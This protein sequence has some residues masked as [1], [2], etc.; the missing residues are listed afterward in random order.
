MMSRL[1]RMRTV[2]VIVMLNL[3]LRYE[4]ENKNIISRFERGCT[5]YEIALL[6]GTLKIENRDEKDDM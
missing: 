6:N 2:E 4:N 5:V 1:E 3:A